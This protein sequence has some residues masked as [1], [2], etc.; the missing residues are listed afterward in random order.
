MKLMYNGDYA[1]WECSWCFYTNRITVKNGERD[2]YWCSYCGRLFF[3][4]PPDYVDF[5]RDVE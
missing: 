5:E 3:V 4:S 2:K 1:T